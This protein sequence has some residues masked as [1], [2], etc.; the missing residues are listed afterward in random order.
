MAVEFLIQT[1]GVKVFVSFL[2]TQAN[3]I[4]VG[5]AT[6]AGASRFSQGLTAPLVTDQETVVR[7]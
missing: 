7:N 6:G 4:N 5:K 1:K 3:A 2:L